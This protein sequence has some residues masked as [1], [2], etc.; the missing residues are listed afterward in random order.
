[1]QDL[2]EQEQQR[3]GT[4]GELDTVLEVSS[5]RRGTYLLV[6]ETPKGYIT[7]KVMLR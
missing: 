1:M 5:L 7:R 2:V 6:V 3:P 4:S